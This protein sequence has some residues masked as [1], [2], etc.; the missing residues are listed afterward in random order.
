MIYELY[1]NKDII[2]KKNTTCSNSCNDKGNPSIKK[3][4]GLPHL[5]PIQK[6]NKMK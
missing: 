5:L 3:W 2:K 4:L 6:E 1:T